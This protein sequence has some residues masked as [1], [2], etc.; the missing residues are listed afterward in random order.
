MSFD[1]LISPFPCLY[2]PENINFRDRIIK[3]RALEALR[4]RLNNLGA[5][6]L[7]LVDVQRKVRNY[8]AV[9]RR[10]RR[11][12]PARQARPQDNSRAPSPD[13]IIIDDY[14]DDWNLL[15]CTRLRLLPPVAPTTETRDEAPPSAAPAE[16]TPDLNPPATPGSVSAECQTDPL[17]DALAFSPDDILAMLQACCARS[18]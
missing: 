12:R 6:D 3:R 5:E 8:Q 17:P 4:I 14:E 13:L 1:E 9:L 2:D 11:R 10:A 18:P 7:D 15:I 16:V